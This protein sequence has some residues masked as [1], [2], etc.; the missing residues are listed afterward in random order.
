MSDD[1]AAHRLLREAMEHPTETREAFVTSATAGRQDLR[2]RVLKWLSSAERVDGFLERPA[3]DRGSTGAG[4]N[5]P[6]SALIGQRVGQYMVRS[7]IACGGM[8]AVY[9]AEQETPRRRVALK[10]MRVGLASR[11]AVR[12][13][14]YEVHVLGQ[15]QHPNIAQV[16]EAA[17]HR[18]GDAEVPFFAMEYIEQAETITGYVQSR[19]LPVRARLELFARVC[20]AVHYGHQRRVIHRDLKPP[21]ILIDVHGDPRVIDFG[22]ARAVEEDDEATHARTLAGEIVGTIGYMSP[23][24]CDPQVHDVDIRCDVYSLGV[25][26]FEV[27]CERAPFALSKVGVVEAAQIIRERVPPRAGTIDDAL[28]GDVETIVAKALEKDRDLRY[29][30][31]AALAADIRRYLRGDP[32]EARPPSLTYQLRLLARR[33]RTVVG[34]SALAVAALIVATLLSLGFALKSGRDARRRAAAETTALAERD[35]AREQTYAA[36]VAAAEAAL[37]VGEYRPMRDRLAAAPEEHRGWEW[38]YLDRQSEPSRLVLQDDAMVYGVRF[39]L[40]DRAVAMATGN[41]RIRLRDAAT[42]AM[43]REVQG[44]TGEVVNAIERSADGRR[45]VA[46]IAGGVLRMWDLETGALLLD[47]HEPAAGRITGVALDGSGGVLGA[48]ADGRVRRWS[49]ATS[50]LTGTYAGHRGVANAVAVGSGGRTGSGGDDGTVRIWSDEAPGDAVVAHLDDPVYAVTFT[51]DGRRVVAGTSPGEIVVLDALTGDR[52]LEWRGHEASVRGISVAADGRTIATAS[53]DRTGAVWDLESGERLHR[54]VAHAEHVHDVDFNEDGTIVATGS[55]DRV[56]RLWDARPTSMDVLTVHGNTVDAVAFSPDG[57]RL[58][59]ASRDGNVRLWDAETLERLGTI[60]HECRFV[61]ALAFTPDSASLAFTR[62]W[63]AIDI[64]DLATG[65]TR[66]VLEGAGTPI[67]RIAFDPTGT[68][69][70]GGTHGGEVI[71]W[72][73]ASG[74]ALDRAD[75]HDGY[76]WD[77]AISPDGARLATGSWDDRVKVWSLR[78]LRELMVLEEHEH[79]VYAVAF[80]PDGRLLVSGGRDQRI[81]VRDAV[82]GTLLETM[83]SHGQFVTGLAFSPRGDR[84]A[85]SGWYFTVKLWDP[86]SWKSLITLQGHTGSIRCLAFSPDGAVIA[87]GA[88]DST[89]RLWVGR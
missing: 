43:I 50:E 51:P 17:T 35:R 74:V 42:G 26:L 77:L 18:I 38:W 70:V 40:G 45:L 82:D 69:L 64:V 55:W 28:S 49:V 79:D 68:L 67:V 23:E 10:V 2:E 86:A 63:Q 9:L 72:D 87:T 41:G 6:T 13:F 46:G 15:L 73:V 3:L 12:R 75:G 83:E 85:S 25:V 47:V 62:T 60:P 32:I 48:C 7:L 34:V 61:R 21:N 57:A 20:Q 8:G 53:G 22:V 81:C 56:A 71:V 33:H 19:R 30:S 84:L 31:A 65:E 16:Y 27:L 88:Q 4:V 54:L 80:S 36:N 66:A 5:D 11:A 58:A 37:R 89:V 59:S 44:V 14:E 29:Q 1:R 24:Q 39:V 52:I 78:P 76:V